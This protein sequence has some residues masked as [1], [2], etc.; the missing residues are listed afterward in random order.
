MIF[1]S[2][3]LPAVKSRLD[4]PGSRVKLYAAGSITAGTGP[5]AFPAGALMTISSLHHL[6]AVSSS[7]DVPGDTSMLI[8]GTAL[9]LPV[10]DGQ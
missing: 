8:S 6:P 5:E 9:H 2:Q 4:V 7:L 3:Y 10:V 1:R